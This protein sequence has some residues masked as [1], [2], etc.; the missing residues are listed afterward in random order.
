LSVVGV[1]ALIGVLF[2]A[3]DRGVVAMSEVSSAFAY[4]LVAGI[5]GL[6]AWGFKPR[7]VRFVK[8][9]KPSIE[10]PIER[11]LQI[12]QELADVKKHLHAHYQNIIERMSKWEYFPKES[13]EMI[14]VRSGAYGVIGELPPNLEKDKMHL[15]EFREVW[16]IYQE[17]PEIFKESKRADEDARSLI[18]PCLLELISSN[19]I[20]FKYWTTED[21]VEK[22]TD[23]IIYTVRSEL[24]HNKTLDFV[25]QKQDEKSFTL[26]PSNLNL[27]NSLEKVQQFAQILNT[28]KQIQDV[29]QKVK[30]QM[31]AWE[32]VIE[33]R[34]AFDNGLREE[35]IE[36]VI[37]SDY[38]DERLSSGV[39]YDCKH[40]KDKRA[41]LSAA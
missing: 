29:R 26:Y 27:Q 33:N 8:A 34:N 23:A 5:L 9:K 19:A 17:G 36:R 16:K 39:C 22:F 1:I 3:L 25:A 12:Q 18:K 13:G 15:K 10:Q 38:T 28:I 37:N 2:F 21:L 31:E 40:L 35:V 24:E 4:L 41:S 6:L 20:S 14:Y 30:E 7:F 11:A 32:K